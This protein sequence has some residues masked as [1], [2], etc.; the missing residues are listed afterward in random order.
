MRA[1]AVALAAS[2]SLA[3]SEPLSAQALR[4]DPELALLQQRDA[5]LYALG[6]RLAT[7]NAAFCQDV[8]PALGL[9]LLDA[10]SF[11]K[12]APVRE[13]LGLS[14]DI[15]VG[16]VAPGSPA[17]IAGIAVNDTILAFAGEAV[18]VRFLASTPAWRR[19]VDVTAYLSDAAAKGPV[20]LLIARGKVPARLVTLKG[21]ASCPT[22]FEVLSRGKSAFSEGTRVILGRD[23]S[24]FT[25]P[26]DLLSAA[27]AHE[28]AH[29]LLHHHAALDRMGRSL[30]N[31][32]LT[33]READRLSPWLLANAGFPP[34]LATRFAETWLRSND[35]GLFRN[36]DHEGW[37]ERAAAIRAE[38]PLVRQAMASEGRADWSRHFARETLTP[39][40]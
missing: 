27:I 4:P 10:G 35:G 7:A 40:R 24:L 15:A 36:R 23:F 33:E 22:R 6:W 13:Q 16:A 34:E 26:D 31:Q 28:L 29:N 38:V 9:Q 30:G 17:D 2:L 8:Q 19:L 18:A 3:A 11:D 21:V 12:P 37:D 20:D 5:R 1:F 39:R 14:G 32:R 25:G